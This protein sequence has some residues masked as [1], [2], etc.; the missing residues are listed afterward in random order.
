MRFWENI[1]LFIIFFGATMS[2]VVNQNKLFNHKNI[3]AN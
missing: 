3:I 1:V 2:I